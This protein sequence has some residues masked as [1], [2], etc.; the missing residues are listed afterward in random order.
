M[1]SLNSGVN[2]LRG[3]GLVEVSPG[4]P[5]TIDAGWREGH[6]EDTRVRQAVH[7]ENGAKQRRI[8]MNNETA[9]YKQE[10]VAPAKTL[11]N[12][13]VSQT[14]LIAGVSVP[15]EPL[16]AIASAAQGAGSGG[17]HDGHRTRL[18][19]LRC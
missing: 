8:P 12:R 1:A 6:R 10:T 7:N 17:R 9:S 5:L 16:D 11:V 2:T 3:E 13:D 14:R 15:N 18:R 4:T 19:W